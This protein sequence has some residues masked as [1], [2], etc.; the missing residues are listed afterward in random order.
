MKNWLKILRKLWIAIVAFG[1]VGWLDYA[2]GY[3]VS[4]EPVYLV[5]IA[6]VSW[7]AGTYVGVLASVL[8]VT[9]RFFA[10]LEAGLKYT[11]PWIR[12][13]NSASTLVTFLAVA[14]A[15]SIY[16]RTV[17]E[18]RKRLAIMRRMLPVCHN[19]GSVQG[20]DGQW[21]PFESLS[22]TPFPEVSECPGCAARL[23]TLEQTT[24]TREG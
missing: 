19:C 17:E 7:Q 11:H 22:N 8:A 2:S 5:L 21:R 16:R 24:G 12:Y 18:H 1:A 23:H 14:Y 13:E 6:Y 10:D 20:A 3:E 15:L 9:I 4:I